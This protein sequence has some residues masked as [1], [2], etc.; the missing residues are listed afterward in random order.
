M[1]WLFEDPAPDLGGSQVWTSLFRATLKL[2]D[3]RRAC[4]IHIILWHFR[5]FGT[6]IQ[7]THQ[8][9]K[10]TPIFEAGWWI[11]EQH[12]EDYKQIFLRPYAAELRECIQR[13]E[14]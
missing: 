1:N 4:Q 2:P 10:M 5:G 11:D 13:M 7:R 12:F 14:E 9:L 8:E 6:V 3:R